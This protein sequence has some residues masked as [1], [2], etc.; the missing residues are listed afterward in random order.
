MTKRYMSK[1]TVMFGSEAPRRMV[2]SPL[3]LGRRQEEYVREGQRFY[4]DREEFE[5][6]V[7]QP[8]RYA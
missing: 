7:S 4:F 1:V 5:V 3:R 6:P 8:N 2:M